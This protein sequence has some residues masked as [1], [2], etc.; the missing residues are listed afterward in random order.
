MLVGVGCNQVVN[1]VVN[2]WVARVAKLDLRQ[3]D[4]ATKPIVGSEGNI[5]KNVARGRD[6]GK[7]YEGR[8][9]Y[10]SSNI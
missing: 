6:V 8:M 9:V 3:S 5:A 2:G 4:Y 7:E 1:N 10:A